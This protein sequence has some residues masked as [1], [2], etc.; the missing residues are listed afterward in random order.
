MHNC[1]LD[2]PHGGKHKC[3]FC[4]KDYDDVTA[5]CPADP[6]LIID[7]YKDMIPKEKFDQLSEIID[8]GIKMDEREE[9]LGKLAVEMA[10]LEMRIYNGI[11]LMNDLRKE[12]KDKVKLYREIKDNPEAS[13]D[14]FEDNIDPL[15]LGISDEVQ[16]EIEDERKK[17]K[18]GGKK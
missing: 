10:E 9:G 14:S 15:E 5:Q 2:H 7:K 1:K 18:K 8:G 13:L 17:E 6:Q 4:K 12:L 3:K 11:L 16:Q